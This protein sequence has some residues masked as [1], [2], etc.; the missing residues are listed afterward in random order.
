MATQGLL[1]MLSLVL[2]ARSTIPAC[3][4]DRGRSET[5]PGGSDVIVPQRLYNGCYQNHKAL[6]ESDL[7][8]C[9]KD[10]LCWPSLQECMPNCPCKVNCGMAPA[11][12]SSPVVRG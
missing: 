1:L 3:V 5:N 8:C 4:S 11:H 7:F 10:K 12:P 2:F 6:Y 9:I